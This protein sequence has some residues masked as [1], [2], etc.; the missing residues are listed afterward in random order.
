[1][2]DP[3]YCIGMGLLLL[4][5]EPELLQQLEPFLVQL[6]RMHLRSCFART[7]LKHLQRRIQMMRMTIIAVD[8]SNVLI[9]KLIKLKLMSMISG[10]SIWFVSTLPMPCWLFAN[11]T[12]FLLILNEPS[13]LNEEPKL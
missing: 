3:M 12:I 5:L 8:C 9:C 1:M 13:F 10:L 2:L 7:I 11:L 6:L 4:S